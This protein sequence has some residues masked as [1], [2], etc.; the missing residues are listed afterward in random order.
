MSRLCP[1]KT[2]SELSVDDFSVCLPEIRECELE[3]RREV[4][5]PV[6]SDEETTYPYLAPGD[7]I[8]STKDTGETLVHLLIQRIG[9]R[10]M[11]YRLDTHDAGRYHYFED[12]ETVVS[13]C[14]ELETIIHRDPFNLRP[15]SDRSGLSVSVK[16][17]VS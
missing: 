10:Y 2:D 12:Y 6:F 1:V 16:E 14:M 9:S 15:I 7:V 11:A 5:L 4:V 3:K 17:P 8:E 13:L